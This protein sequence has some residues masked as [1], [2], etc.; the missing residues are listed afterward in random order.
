MNARG[1]LRGIVRQTDDPATRHRLETHL[2]AMT[3]A[4]CRSALE[5]LCDGEFEDD[6]QA[7]PAAEAHKPGGIRETLHDMFG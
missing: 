6:N 7:D 2:D 5:F 3:E 1:T 4:E